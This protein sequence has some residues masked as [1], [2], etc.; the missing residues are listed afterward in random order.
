MIKLNIIVPVHEPTDWVNSIVPVEKLDGSLRL[1]LDPHLNKAIE[2]PYY[3]LPT[4][5]KLLAQMSKAKYFTKLDASCA[6]W[7]IQLDYESF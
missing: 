1:C 4:T 3:N 6:Y 5:E 7:Q 2:R